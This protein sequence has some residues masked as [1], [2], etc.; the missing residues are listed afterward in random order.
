MMFG[1]ISLAPGIPFHATGTLTSHHIGVCTA[2]TSV[3][4]WFV[5]IKSGMIF[6]SSLYHF[7]VM[8]YIVLSMMIV[9]IVV[10]FCLAQRNFVEGL[11]VGGV[12]G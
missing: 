3:F 8:A 5:Y 4:D 12:K 7:T 9:P 10:I 2:D 6:C 1:G 11:T